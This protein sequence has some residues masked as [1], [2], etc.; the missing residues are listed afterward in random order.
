MNVKNQDEKKQDVKNARLQKEYG[1]VELTNN[2][3][4]M[5]TLWSDY[6]LSTHRI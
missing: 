6:F 5:R 4:L 1:T 3:H 2:N